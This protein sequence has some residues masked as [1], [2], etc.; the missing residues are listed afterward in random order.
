MKGFW[1]IEIAYDAGRRLMFIHD[2]YSK[3]PHSFA[4]LLTTL[5]NKRDGWD[6]TVEVRQNTVLHVDLGKGQGH[7]T[8]RSFVHVWTITFPD[9]CLTG[10]A[11]RFYSQAQSKVRSI[12]RTACNYVVD[13]INSTLVAHA[14]MHKAT[15]RRNS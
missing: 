11:L 5:G 4:Q 8:T 9:P 10:E 7:K 2:M 6:T 12:T 13:V 3:K 15:Q 14:W 1:V